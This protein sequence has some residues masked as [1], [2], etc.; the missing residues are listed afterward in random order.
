MHQVS[1]FHLV[2]YGSECLSYNDRHLS[3]VTSTIPLAGVD[4]SSYLSAIPP[5]YIYHRGIY[6]PKPLYM[7]LC[8]KRLQL[9]FSL[10][11]SIISM[12]NYLSA[13]D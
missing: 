3:D 6:K 7:P 13:N 9:T 2:H 4:A 8:A 10:S 1:G 11:D 5:T 12:H